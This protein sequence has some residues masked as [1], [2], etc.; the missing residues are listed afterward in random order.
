LLKSFYFH[1]YSIII[2]FLGKIGNQMTR[3]YHYIL[4]NSKA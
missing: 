2:I 4:K 1:S 3:S